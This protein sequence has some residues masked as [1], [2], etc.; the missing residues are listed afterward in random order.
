MDALKKQ[1]KSQK[2]ERLLL[3]KQ[4]FHN[5]PPIPWSEMTPDLWLHGLEDLRQPGEGN[6]SRPFFVSLR[7]PGKP[8][9]LA[10]VKFMMRGSSSSYYF[11]DRILTQ[12]GARTPGFRFLQPANLQDQP[13]LDALSRSVRERVESDVTFGEGAALDPTSLE[14]TDGTCTIF[15]RTFKLLIMGK[16]GKKK[17]RGEEELFEHI[18]K[19]AHEQSFSDLDS[20]TLTLDPASGA[21]KCDRRASLAEEEREIYDGS[22]GWFAR[23]RQLEEGTCEAIMVFEYVKGNRLNEKLRDGELEEAA[24]AEVGAPEHG[25]GGEAAMSDKMSRVY[26]KIGET[27]VGDLILNNWDRF[28]V[29]YVWD[30]AG[31]AGNVLLTDDWKVI[32]IDHEVDDRSEANYA[33]INDKVEKF[34]ANIQGI[35]ATEPIL[36]VPQLT[37]LIQALLKDPEDEE[38]S[39]A[40]P[41]SAL[42]QHKFW[43]LRGLVRGVF[44]VANFPRL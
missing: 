22:V 34:F 17:F 24:A 4:V 10:V 36:D 16:S 18:K 7:R 6:T 14:L 20:C 3:K 12:L 26:E 31:N 23:M 21:I 15:G 9:G 38:P 19:K 28:S 30:S 2:D 40:L 37:A 39:P 33:V 13:E 43:V 8:R 25:G 44:L 29:P 11:G 32:S 35:D 42:H 27:L 1:V 5:T 41:T